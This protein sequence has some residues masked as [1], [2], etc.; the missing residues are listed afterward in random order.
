MQIT[1]NGDPKTLEDGL[2]ILGLLQEL[3]YQ[4][5]RLA[6]ECNGDIIPRSQHASTVLH[7]G[8]TVEIV[9]AVGGG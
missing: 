9:M 4:E 3:G 1:L 5:R 2:T 6:V 7:D 8:D